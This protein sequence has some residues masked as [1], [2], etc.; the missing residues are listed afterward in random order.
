VRVSRSKAWASIGAL[1][2]GMRASTSYGQSGH[3]LPALYCGDAVPLDRRRARASVQTG[4]M[5]RAHAGSL[6]CSEAP[7]AAWMA[8]RLVDG[9]VKT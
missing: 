7:G 1:L 4:P 2:L 3:Q 5:L 9:I 8:P 6:C